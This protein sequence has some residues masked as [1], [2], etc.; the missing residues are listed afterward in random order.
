MRNLIAQRPNL[1]PVG[2]GHNSTGIS[3]GVIMPVRTD[4]ADVDV[5]VDELTDDKEEEETHFGSWDR[6]PEAAGTA[7]PR[8][9]AVAA[10]APSLS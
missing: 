8:P 6:T 5:D 1:V 10:S 9:Q 4:A 2:V 7:P 3:A